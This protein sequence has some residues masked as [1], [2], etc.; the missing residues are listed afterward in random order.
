MR[1]AGF[2][3]VAAGLVVTA[4]GGLRDTFTS[5]TDTAAKVGDLELPSARVAEI[6]TRLGGPTANPEAAG[7][8]TGIWVDMAL[9]A[10][11][12]AR[13]ELETDSVTLSKLMWPQI[14]ESKI[15]AW[16]DSVIAR[17]SAITPAEVDSFYNAGEI[18][19]FQHILI[20]PAGS[21]VADTARARGQA[22]R[23]LAQ[24]RT[25]DF[26]KLA[27]QHSSDGSKSD[28]GYLP[29]GPRGTPQRPVFVPEFEGPAW[30]LAPGGI[31]GVVQ[32]QFGFHIIR[33]PPL[34]EVRDRLTPTYTQ[35]QV[36]K[37]DSAYM[38]DLTT[39]SELT[40]KPGAAAAVRTA[41]ADPSAARKSGKELAS[42]KGGS[43][44]VKDLVPWLEALP[45]Q[46]AV[47]I[48]TANDT[49]L[50]GFVKSLAQNEILL[51]Q[52]DSAK[53]T[54][55]PAL[56]QQMSS[57]FTSVIGALREAMGLNGPEFA[58]TTKTPEA[59]RRA[60][61]AGKVNEYFDKLVKGEAQFR[62]IPPTLT[63]ELRG[64]GDFKIYQQGVAKAR[65]LVIAQ[66]ARD[67]AAAGG[68]QGPGLQPAP[69]GPPVPPAPDSARTP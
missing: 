64:E 47:Q 43:F 55:N 9:F 65:E 51:K 12:V 32:S 10:D 3:L 52:A 25:G 44:D 23:V 67:S 58:D 39:R 34:A 60:L 5:R 30:E 11:R 27:Q 19:L 15:Q 31:T 57:Q 48:K 14:S 56:Y 49:I 7:L 61:A 35:M 38:A 63:A 36:S 6:I 37:A 17:R 62:Q 68:A 22:E 24:A 18:R 2:A 53:V 45:M 50:E 40:V 66:R 59:E 21:T 16:H 13:G 28:G 1:R 42:Y 33:R 54:V 29:P 46:S 69:G 4:C 26:A 20:I 41:V 8:I